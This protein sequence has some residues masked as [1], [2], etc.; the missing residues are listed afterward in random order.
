MSAVRRIRGAI[1]NFL[2]MYVSRYSDHEGY[3]LFGYLV[4][5]L[6]TLHIDLLHPP[7]DERAPFQRAIDVAT[8]RFREQLLKAGID[9]DVVRTAELT[10]SRQSGALPV[11]VNDAT[12]VGWEILAVVRVESNRGRRFETQRRLKVARHNP[13]VEFKSARTPEGT[14]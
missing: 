6:E 2:G 1:G 14:S 4:P 5:E 11:V 7:E 8:N 10:L 9:I 12:A 13:S 3:W